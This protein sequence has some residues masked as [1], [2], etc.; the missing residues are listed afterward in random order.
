ML[1]YTG[2]GLINIFPALG[3]GGSSIIVM[4]ITLLS[5]FLLSITGLYYWHKRVKF[6]TQLLLGAWVITVAFSIRASWGAAFISIQT[7]IG[8]PV[9]VLLAYTMWRDRIS[10]KNT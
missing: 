10:G 5:V 7:L 2:R 1:L 6:G 3:I 9:L 8:I 4:F